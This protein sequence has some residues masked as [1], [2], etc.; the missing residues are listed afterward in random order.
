[1]NLRESDAGIVAFSSAVPTSGG[2]GMPEQAVPSL[3]RYPVPGRSAEINRRIAAH[4]I[5]HALVGRCLGTELHSVTIIPAG[6]FEGRCRSIAYQAQQF[7]A[8]P[9][10][11]T[12]EI[13]DL[14]DRARQLMPEL[15]VNR[16]EA[17]EFF[18]RATVLCIEF[19]AGTVAEQI[20]HPD[21]EPLPTVH[22]AIEA[23]AFASL[24]VA[25]QRAIPAFLA[26]CRAEAAALITDN[27]AIAEA[28]ID[29]LIEHGELSGAAVDEIIARASAEESLIADR[30]RQTDWQRVIES[31]ARLATFVG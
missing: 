25:S 11:Q 21:L 17:A 26:Y 23:E 5:G 19:V 14:C 10:N 28:I 16:I 8:P 1:M 15:G 9:E 20:F 30:K 13:V 24:A 4:E 6:G 2:D 3:A 31:A 29:A 18:Q 22:D 12:T 7:Y 27:R